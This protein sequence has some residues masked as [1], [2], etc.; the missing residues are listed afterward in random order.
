[1]TYATVAMI[2]RD[3]D[4]SNRVAACV[5]V[6]GL[7]PYPEQWA[8]ERGWALAAQPGWAAAWASALTTHPDDPE[9]RPG[10]DEG[11][12]TD[13]MILSAVQALNAAPGAA[14]SSVVESDP[15]EV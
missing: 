2:R 14:K 8:A 12:I 13:G 4:I 3:S 5:A 1:M 11:V 6:E 9:Y 10:W 15:E 7:S